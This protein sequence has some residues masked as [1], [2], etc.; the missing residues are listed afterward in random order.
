M[1]YKTSSVKAEFSWQLQ[2]FPQ[3]EDLEGAWEAMSEFRKR[4]VNKRTSRGAGLLC[5]LQ[6]GWQCVN[7][8]GKSRPWASAKEIDFV[9]KWSKSR[10]DIASTIAALRRFRSIGF[11]G[12]RMFLV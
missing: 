11:P 1:S 8:N 9:T 2:R 4:W 10:S 5:A 12:F 6:S 3:K 7:L